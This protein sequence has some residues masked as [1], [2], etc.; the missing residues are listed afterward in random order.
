MEKQEQIKKEINEIINQTL[1]N[2]SSGNSSAE[3]KKVSERK[4]EDGLKAIGE[5]L[6]YGEVKIAH[7][8]ALYEGSEISA[9][10]HYPEN[11]QFKNDADKRTEASE[12]EKLLSCTPSVTGQKAI[13]KKLIKSLIGDDITEQDLTKIYSEIDSAP[14][15]ISNPQQLSEL[16]DLN[17]LSPE[18]AA[19]QAGFDKSEAVKAKDAATERAVAIATAQSLGTQ[20]A[21]GNNDLS[22]TPGDDAK[23]EKD[24]LRMEGTNARK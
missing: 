9:E 23:L 3:S 8:F 20:G 10:I 24:A 14:G 7:F 22:P 13:A 21:R 6:E 18:T 12:L 16:V 19:I 4:E 1:K 15:A 5:E 11:F 2:I 17:I